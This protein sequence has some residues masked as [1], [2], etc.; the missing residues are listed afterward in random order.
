MKSKQK[1]SVHLWGPDLW[2][3][4]TALLLSVIICFTGV[5]DRELCTPD[6]P[7]VAAICLEMSQNNNFIVPHLA[8]EPFVEKPPLYFAVA[9]GLIRTIGPLTGSTDA[10]RLSSAFWGVGIIV[11]TFLLARLLASGLNDP[12]DNSAAYT[13]RFALTAAVLLAT[14]TTFIKQSHWIRVDVALAFFV[15]AAIW[16]FAEAHFCNRKK[17]L[18]LAAV[19]SAGAFLSKGALGPVMIGIGW[20]GMFLPR[21]IS[22]LSSDRKEK[23]I[24]KYYFPSLLLFLILIIAWI[25]AL[26]VVGGREIFDEWFFKNQIGRFTG[27]SG[28][29][30]EKGETPFYYL[31]KLLSHALPWTPLVLIWFFQVVTDFRKRGFR[32]LSQERIF[33]LV[34]SLGTLGVLTAAGSKRGLYLFPLMPVFGIMCA[35]VLQ[36]VLPNWSR[37]Y[38]RL[39]LFLCI[40]VLAGLAFLPL[41]FGLIP[42]EL[43]SKYGLSP[44]EWNYWNAVSGLCLIG[45]AGLVFRFRTTFTFPLIVLAVAAVCLCGIKV[46]LPLYNAKKGMM[47]KNVKNFIEKIDFAERP[48]IASYRFTENLMG[49]FYI[50]GGWKISRIDTI[51]RVNNILEGKDTSF[52]SLIISTEQPLSAL[53][54]NPLNSCVINETRVEGPAEKDRLLWV[55]SD[56]RKLQLGHGNL[57]GQNLN[58]SRK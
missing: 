50:A 38:F 39:L 46:T 57:S 28:L 6:E 17:F 53:V 54:T 14:M 13:C 10:I 36:R 56:S 31:K 25:A 37:F 49:L 55:M 16:S 32:A 1:A 4:Y 12:S 48:R 29:G 40:A 9:A 8:G 41:L 45:V 15:I 24:F 44:M 27:S 33:L 19:F 21:M 52:D 58:S 23:D 47:E 5:F 22:W 3:W 20:A 51:D 43:L 35:E 34:W 18:F 26:Y 30:H 11:M 2:P 7:R 42:Q